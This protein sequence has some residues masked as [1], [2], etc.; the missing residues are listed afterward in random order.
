MRKTTQIEGHQK[1]D[2]LPDCK[3]NKCFV[4]NYVIQEMVSSNR[5]K[6][7]IRS[8]NCGDHQLSDLG[9]IHQ[10]ETNTWSHQPQ[11][12]D[13]SHPGSRNIIDGDKTVKILLTLISL[14]S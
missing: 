5:Y 7:L 3:K 9:Y 12:L 8:E 2:N 10:E 13:S 11:N 4:W 6:I 1:N 14:S